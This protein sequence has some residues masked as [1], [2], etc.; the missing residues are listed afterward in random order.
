MKVKVGNNIKEISLVKKE[1][2]KVEIL[3]DDKT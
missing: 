2:N 3:V 1:D